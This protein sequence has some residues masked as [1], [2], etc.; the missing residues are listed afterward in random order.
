MSSRCSEGAPGPHHR[1][2]EE[3]GFH[4]LTKQLKQKHMALNLAFYLR[5]IR[6]RCNCLRRNFE[7][8]V[9]REAV[10][11]FYRTQLQA[12]Y[13]FGVLGNKSKQCVTRRTVAEFNKVLS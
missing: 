9:Q 2:A 1:D 13:A 11:P 6:A 8:P 4:T 7:G 5:R 3:Y 10:I 12:V